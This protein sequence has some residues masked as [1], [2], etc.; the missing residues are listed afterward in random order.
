MVGLPLSGK[1]TFLAA[2][3]TVL[4][5]GE[6]DSKLRLEQLGQDDRWLNRIRRSWSDCE[7]VPRNAMG[8]HEPAELNLIDIA[9]SRLVNLE[10][11]DLNGETFRDLWIHRT[12]S[13]EFK[14]L[15][16]EA[17]GIVLFIHPSNVVEPWQIKDQNEMVRAIGDGTDEDGNNE[18]IS[19]TPVVSAATHGAEADMLPEAANE[20]EWDPADAPTQVQL[21]DALQHLN[22]IYPSTPLAKKTIAVVVSAWDVVRAQNQTPRQWL[23]RRLPLLY[24]LLESTVG[25]DGFRIFGVS[26]TGG[27]LKKDR[28]KLLQVERCKRIEVVG[29]GVSNVNDLTEPLQ[30]LIAQT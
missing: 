7:E 21:V 19:S 1:T 8:P 10:F 15:A 23:Q 14:K 30:W 24:Q 20:A 2:L 27:D 11:P 3:T 12:T 17:K 5:S 9:S 25:I 4:E 26:A 22:P 28:D 29:E 6:V 18:P 16:D 13:I